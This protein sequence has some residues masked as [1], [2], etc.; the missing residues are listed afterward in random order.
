MVDIS[1]TVE[2]TIEILIDY[3]KGGLTLAQAVDRFSKLTGIDQNISEKYIRELGRDNIISLN[4]KRQDR[5]SKS[6]ETDDRA[7]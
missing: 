7:G 1:P 5:A 2:G 4:S 6:E 3:K